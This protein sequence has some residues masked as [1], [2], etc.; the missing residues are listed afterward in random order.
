[1]LEQRPVGLRILFACSYS[2]PTQLCKPTS[3]I[4]FQDR[5]ETPL[6]QGPVLLGFQS[7]TQRGSDPW[8]VN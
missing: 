8:S 5:A 1:M 6:Q 4:S 2:K 7:Q 3:Y